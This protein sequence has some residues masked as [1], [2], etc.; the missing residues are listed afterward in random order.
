M[1]KKNIN[2]IKAII[3]T[4]MKLQICFLDI[5]LLI[6]HLKLLCVIKMILYCMK[7]DF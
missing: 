4:L 7:I 5:N 2:V 6:K 3:D 1:N